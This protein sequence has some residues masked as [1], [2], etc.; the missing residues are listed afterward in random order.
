[1]RLANTKRKLV[2]QFEEVLRQVSVDCLL[3]N[4]SEKCLSVPAG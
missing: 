3:F 4:P 1:M 2:S